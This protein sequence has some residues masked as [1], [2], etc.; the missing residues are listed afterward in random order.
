MLADAAKEF[1]GKLYVHGGGWN[2]LNVFDPQAARPISIAGRVLIPWGSVEREI[3][4]EIS[5][6][7]I[8]ADVVLERAPLMRM[9]MQAQSRPDTP[10]SLETATP[11]VLDIPGV[12]FLR[13]GEYAF[14][15]DRGGQE[16]ARTRFQVNFV[17][18]IESGTSDKGT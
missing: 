8:E 18:P 10:K 5:L 11:F 15:I 1:E 16:L 12:A 7:H 9:V 3:T 14:V 13:P 2:F 4:L 17:E 6:E